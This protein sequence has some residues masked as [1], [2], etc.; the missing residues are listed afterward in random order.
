MSRHCE[1]IRD[2][3]GAVLARVQLT[4][5]LSDEEREALTEFVKLARKKFSEEPKAE[6]S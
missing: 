5:P 3:D 2:D 1:V 4:G 6:P